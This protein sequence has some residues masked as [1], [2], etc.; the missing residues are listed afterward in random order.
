MKSF[1]Q[2]LSFMIIFCLLFECF[3]GI[4]TPISTKASGGV[5]NLAL[6]VI[7]YEED[8]RVGNLTLGWNG[9]SGTES[10]LVKYHDPQKDEGFVEEISDQTVNTYEIDG[11]FEDNYMYDIYCFVTILSYSG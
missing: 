10:I 9:V 4:I 6:N 1:K 7:N 8:G 5:T 3:V 2:K 11:T